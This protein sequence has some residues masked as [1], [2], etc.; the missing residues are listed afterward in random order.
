MASPLLLNHDMF[1]AKPEI[2]AIISNKEVLAVNQD[3]LGAMA[4]RI[5]GSMVHGTSPATQ[6]PRLPCKCT[7]TFCALCD[8]ASSLIDCAILTDT[9][10]SYTYGEQLAKPLANGDWAVLL[11]N[12]LDVMTQIVLN[13]LDVGNTSHRCFRVRDLWSHTDLGVHKGTF[14]GGVLST[15]GSRLVRLSPYLIGSNCTR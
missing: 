4:T 7:H 3:P 5:D 11:L 9:A 8:E 13:F 1:H 6:I 10:S 2:T 15:H 12:R 14:D